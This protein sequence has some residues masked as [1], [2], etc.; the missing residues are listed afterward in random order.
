MQHVAVGDDIILAFEPEFAG[1]PRA[2][3]AI[4]GDIIVIG[5]GLGADKAL[6]EIRVDDARRLRRP[7]AP[8]SIVQARAS[9][10]PAVK[11]VTSCKS[12]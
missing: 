11:K 1:L 8:C 2:R 9:F 7:C 3:F 12:S 6:F 10:G 5:D 4:A